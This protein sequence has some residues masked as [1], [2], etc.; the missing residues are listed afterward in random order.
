MGDE[1]S[2]RLS[3]I[4]GD[5]GYEDHEVGRVDNFAAVFGKRAAYVGKQYEN[6][7]ATE[8]LSM[9]L[10]EMYRDPVGFAKADPDYFD[11]VVGVMR[12]GKG[13]KK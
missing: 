2:R 4:T 9:G 12:S 10:E 6:D 3:D 7:Y 5:P 11:F 8:V 1:K 13:K